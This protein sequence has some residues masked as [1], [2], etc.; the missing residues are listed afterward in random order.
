MILKR[1]FAG[2]GWIGWL[3]LLLS[4]LDRIDRF[5]ISRWSNVEFLL[6][7]VS[8]VKGWSTILGSVWF[9]FTL[10]VAGLVIIAWSAHR[11]G[12]RVQ[13]SDGPLHIPRRFASQVRDMHVES[14]AKP[15]KIVQAG[16]GT[17]A[18]RH[19]EVDDLSD[20]QRTKLFALDDTMHDWWR[21]KRVDGAWPRFRL[22]GGIWITEAQLAGLE[23]NLYTGLAHTVSGLLDWYLR[24]KK[25]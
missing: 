11:I 3:L 13:I 4:Q 1:L 19:A 24:D 15:F 16:G 17:R 22:P 8:G 9:Q 6:Q 14:R 23:R 18:Y 12:T 5:I 10:I 7:K 2:K 20:Q 21:G 25:F